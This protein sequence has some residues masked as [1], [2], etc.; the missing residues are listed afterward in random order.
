MKT[1]DVAL[2]E[3][4]ED[5]ISLDGGRSSKKVFDRIAMERIALAVR[6][7]M[8]TQ[9]VEMV[10]PRGDMLLESNCQFINARDVIDWA[11]VTYLHRIHPKPRLELLT[12]QWLTNFDSLSEAV[13]WLQDD[14]R[15]RALA[16]AK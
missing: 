7:N 8:A 3:W 12:A 6:N 9:V 5:E 14:V 4:V 13:D 10:M 15:R 16:T 11:T 1:P 2:R